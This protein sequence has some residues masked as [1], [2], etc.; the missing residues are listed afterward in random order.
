MLNSRDRNDCRCTPPQFPSSDIGQVNSLK[1]E[2]S[3]CRITPLKFEYSEQNYSCYS[4]TLGM[5]HMCGLLEM[6]CLLKIDLR[7]DQR[8]FTRL[9]QS[10]AEGETILEDMSL[11]SL[12][13]A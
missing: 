6:I 12:G 11:V 9:Q 4:V 3:A 10:R 1:T 2:E 8:N 5:G 13:K 7:G